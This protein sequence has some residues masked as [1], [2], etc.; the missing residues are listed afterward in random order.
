MARSPRLRQVISGTRG[1]RVAPAQSFE[2]QS[3]ATPDGRILH[4]A[5]HP[6]RHRRRRPGRS[7]ARAPAP[8]QGIDSV[9]LETPIGR[10]RRRTGAGRRPRAGHRRFADRHRP[11]RRGS[12]G[13]ACGTTA[14]TSRST[15]ARHRIDMAALTGGRAITIYGQNEVVRDS[16]RRAPCVGRTVATAR[17]RTCRCTTWTARGP[18]RRFDQRAVVRADVRLDCGLRWLSRA[19]PRGDS[20]RRLRTF[21]RVYPF[22]WLGILAEALPDVRRAGVQPS[23]PRLRAL[24]HAL[25]AITRLY[26]QVRA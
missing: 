17:C 15:G 5:P 12:R 21:E 26:L 6:G 14:S 2:V 3:L 8:P 18:V 19:V 7:H 22:A 16:D 11:W 24:Q 9:I 25:S 20:R 10:P 23:R 4:C 1:G 13:R